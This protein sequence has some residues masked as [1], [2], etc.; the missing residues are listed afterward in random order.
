MRDIDGKYL[1]NWYDKGTLSQYHWT[2]DMDNSVIQS[3]DIEYF[4]TLCKQNEFREAYRYTYF[5]FVFIYR[6]T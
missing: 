3:P 4:I 2:K 5:E 1:A 6:I